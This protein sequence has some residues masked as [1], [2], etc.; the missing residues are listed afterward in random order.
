[1]QRPWAR[2]ENVQIPQTGKK[3]LKTNRD[4]EN[5]HAEQVR[6]LKARLGNVALNDTVLRKECRKISD[7]RGVFM[8]NS[9][10]PLHT[11]GCF[12]MNTDVLGNAGIHWVAVVVQGKTVNI[13]DSFA[14][15]ARNL[16]PIFTQRIKA[17]GFRVRNAD[18]NDQDQY[19]STSVDCGHRCIS[20]LLL[21]RDYGVPT[22]LKL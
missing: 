10:V 14:R 3:V 19:G 13:Y 18:L 12:V 20:A 21:Y 6:K 2:Q 22:F 15:Y 5:H 4:V 17:E 9:R 16:L 11:N 8:Q 7:F 1:V